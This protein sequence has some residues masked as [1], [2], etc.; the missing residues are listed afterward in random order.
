M[1]S[2]FRKRRQAAALL[3]LVFACLLGIGIT[4]ADGW[5]MLLGP[6]AR[7]L[8]S[9]TFEPTPVRLERGKYLTEA[10]MGC[11]D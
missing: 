7:A 10:V 3:I 11:F 6:R 2:R 9:R 1:K 4:M 5:V 8:T